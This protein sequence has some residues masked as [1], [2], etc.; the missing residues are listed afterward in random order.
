MEY[1]KMTDHIILEKGLHVEC[2]TRKQFEAWLTVNGYG[3]DVDYESD[4]FSC[5][6]KGMTEILVYNQ[7]SDMWLAQK[8]TEAIEHLAFSTISHYVQTPMGQQGVYK[9]KSEIYKE[10]MEF[11]K[12]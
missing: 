8:A 4:R 6:Y 5:W 10:I 3:L 7:G 2:P 1:G 12:E 11:P 9:T